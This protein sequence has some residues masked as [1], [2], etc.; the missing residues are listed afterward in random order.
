V[1]IY[2]NNVKSQKNS[3]F[4]LNFQQNLTISGRKQGIG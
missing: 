3:E 4:S 2:F 1:N